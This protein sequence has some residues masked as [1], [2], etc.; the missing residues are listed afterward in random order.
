MDE[1]VPPDVVGHTEQQLREM[2]QMTLAAAKEEKNRADA[3]QARVQQ[4]TVELDE[5][6]RQAEHHKVEHQQ[7]RK[8]LQLTVAAAKEEKI[9]ADEE[10]ARAQRVAAEVNAAQREVAQG[11]APNSAFTHIALS[12][13]AKRLVGATANTLAIIDVHTGKPVDVVRST[14][15]GGVSALSYASDGLRVLS[16]GED[17]KLRLWRVAEDKDAGFV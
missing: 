3:E 9:R 17:G 6:Q 1:G 16:A 12:P 5:A 4:L 13:F 10:E 11:K 15:H 14:G 2:L 8:M 7:A